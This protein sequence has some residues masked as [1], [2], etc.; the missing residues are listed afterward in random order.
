MMTVK[1]PSFSGNSPNSVRQSADYRNNKIHKT[2]G[3]SNEPIH[4]R[5]MKDDVLSR[6]SVH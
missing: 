2:S 1:M 5:R 4:I 6:S 3:I